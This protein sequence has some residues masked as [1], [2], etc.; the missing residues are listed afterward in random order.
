MRE[1]SDPTARDAIDL[2]LP[3][4]QRLADVLKILRAHFSDAAL[5]V[6]RNKAGAKRTIEITGELAEVLTRITTRPQVRR[7]AHLIQDDDV[8]L[9]SLLA[10]HGRFNKAR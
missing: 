5:F 4:D 9:L 7:S 2:P 3:A 6:A 1:M 10:L 8:K